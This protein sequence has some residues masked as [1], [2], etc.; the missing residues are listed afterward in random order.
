MLAHASRMGTSLALDAVIASG[1]MKG[2]AT[3]ILHVSACSEQ[4]PVTFAEVMSLSWMPSRTQCQLQRTQSHLDQMGCPA[5][6]KSS[7]EQH[8]ADDTGRSEHHACPPV[9]RGRSLPCLC[10][11]AGC[12]HMSEQFA[13]SEQN[14]L[15]KMQGSWKML[16][17]CE[18]IIY[19]TEIKIWEQWL[20]TSTMVAGESERDTPARSIKILQMRHVILRLNMLKTGETCI[21]LYEWVGAVRL[22]W[23]SINQTLGVVGYCGIMFRRPDFFAISQVQDVP[24]SPQI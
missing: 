5:G 19:R 15:G 22:L 13:C 17:A 3:R 9:E 8:D 24:F 10:K 20:L 18:P 21:I 16:H 6:R 2:A 14:M 1:G 7:S 11:A 12:L 4:M 23:G